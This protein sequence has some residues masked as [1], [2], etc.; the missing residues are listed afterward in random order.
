MAQ[1]QDPTAMN[2][3]PSALP[4]EQP[5]ESA[6]DFFSPQVRYSGAN[7]QCSA[8]EYFDGT[9]KCSNQNKIADGGPNVEPGGRC[10]EFDPASDD[11][12]SGGPD[13]LRQAIAATK[14]F[15]MAAGGSNS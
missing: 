5:E 12:E 9:G 13:A 6:Q 4:D 14:P 8:C 11:G 10:E 1:L 7:V 2:P 3:N 15:G